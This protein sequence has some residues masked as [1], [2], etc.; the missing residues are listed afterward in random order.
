MSASQPILDAAAYRS[1]IRRTRAAL[2][3]VKRLVAHRGQI[4]DLDAARMRRE[5]WSDA[6]ILAIASK[7]AAG[8]PG[9]R[10]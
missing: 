8:L 5:G 4:S 7:A 6:E 9:R 3:F 1:R 2:D 10:D